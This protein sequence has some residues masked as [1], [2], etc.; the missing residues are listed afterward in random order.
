VQAAVTAIETRSGIAR[1]TKPPQ[2][3]WHVPESGFKDV[4]LTTA[5]LWAR[6]NGVPWSFIVEVH[7]GYT[8]SQR[9]KLLTLAIEELSKLLPTPG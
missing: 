2:G 4:S 8:L 3:V 5:S 9:V 7:D 1:A 6:E